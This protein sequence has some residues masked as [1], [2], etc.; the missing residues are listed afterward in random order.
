M[1]TR[2]RDNN[3]ANALILL[4]QS[5]LRQTRGG[6]TAVGNPGDPEDANT[7]ALRHPN[8]AGFFTIE[9]SGGRISAD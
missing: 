3:P 1:N 6:G 5:Q 8:P 2:Q 7:V 4:T 9:I